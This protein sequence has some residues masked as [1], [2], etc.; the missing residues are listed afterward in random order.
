MN[1][2]YH[3]II[4]NFNN[5]LYDLGTVC[6]YSQSKDAN[7]TQNI[8]SSHA[9]PVLLF[10]ADVAGD[11]L[12]CIVLVICIGFLHVTSYCTLSSVGHGS[13]LPWAVC[14]SSG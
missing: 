9:S 13:S 2:E 11:K 5:L 3:F 10:L 14:I 7:N 12:P 4:F 1:I 8:I 6:I